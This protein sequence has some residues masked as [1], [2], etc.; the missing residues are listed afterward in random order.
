MEI[1][2]YFIFGSQDF[3]Q[4]AGLHVAE[5]LACGR[6]RLKGPMQTTEDGFVLPQRMEVV[7]PVGD[8]HFFQAPVGISWGYHIWT[9]LDTSVLWPFIMWQIK[10]AG[11]KCDVTPCWYVVCVGQCW[12]RRG[13]KWF[14]NWLTNISNISTVAQK[15][16]LLGVIPTL[17]HYSDIFWH[18]YIV[19]NIPFGR[20]YGI[21][22]LTF[23]LTYF[24][25]FY[26]ASILTFFLAF[27][28]AYILTF[29][30]TFFLAF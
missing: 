25:A 2:K 19:S 14:R 8:D 3:R 27:F 11:G 6:V 26:L 15:N 23:Y 28:L 21:S 7:T 1:K 10:V 13:D 16:T 29:V 20:I 5:H 12:G 24:L 30:L 4:T 9:F 22:I 18:S 17:T